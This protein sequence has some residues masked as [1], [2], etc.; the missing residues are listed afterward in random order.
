MENILPA[1]YTQIK[2]FLLAVYAEGRGNEEDGNENA[3]NRLATVTCALTANE[4][5]E[6]LTGFGCS[7]A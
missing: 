3:P 2:N 7:T 4:I 6:T 5:N 1:A